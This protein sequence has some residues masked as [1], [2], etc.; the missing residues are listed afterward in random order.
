MGGRA[1]PAGESGLHEADGGSPVS[2]R[3]LLYPQMAA[4][5]IHGH[6][7]WALVLVAVSVGESAGKAWA[8]LGF[9]EQLPTAIPG[10]LLSA[11]L[12]QR[13]ALGKVGAGDFSPGCTPAAILPHRLLPG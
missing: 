3:L 5:P 12:R 1:C 10:A 9:G 2:S 11:L 4:D 8:S 7:P 13:K 6:P